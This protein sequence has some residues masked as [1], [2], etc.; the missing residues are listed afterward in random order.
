ML[1]EFETYLCDYIKSRIGVYEKCM[2]AALDN[3]D[4]GCIQ[5]LEC[6]EG[7][8]IHNSELKNCELLRDA[9][10]FT[11]DIKLSH[12]GRS[13]YRCFHLTDVGKRFAEALKQQKILDRCDRLGSKSSQ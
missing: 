10:L 5:Y 4:D 11:E 8:F 6:S 7:V 12:H 9:G 1:A 3:K 13:Y 2:L